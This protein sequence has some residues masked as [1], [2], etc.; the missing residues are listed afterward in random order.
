[1]QWGFCTKYKIILGNCVCNWPTV[2]CRLSC[3][4]V[5]S[6]LAF[7]IW[8]MWLSRSLP[9]E[10]Y[11][12]SLWCADKGTHFT[13]KDRHGTS[14]RSENRKWSKEKPVAPSENAKKKVEH[15]FQMSEESSFFCA[16]DFP[17]YLQMST[18]SVLV[19]LWFNNV[20]VEQGH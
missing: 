9:T 7:W 11:P 2:S 1:M 8:L 10:N 13:E 3:V 19:Y 12:S 5:R 14:D 16:F 4:F 17:S 6:I 20:I 18:Q 15:A